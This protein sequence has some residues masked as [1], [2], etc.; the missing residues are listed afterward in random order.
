ML[1]IAGR[2]LR[3]QRRLSREAPR[4]VKL[5]GWN[6]ATRSHPLQ[7][8]VAL[9]RSANAAMHGRIKEYST[10]DAAT[11]WRLLFGA[12]SRAQLRDGF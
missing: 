3:Y 7:N 1:R 6:G 8:A 10:P 5:E 2:N 9:V 4:V 11:R 12:V